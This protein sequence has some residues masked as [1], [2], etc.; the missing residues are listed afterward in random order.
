M[1]HTSF[2]GLIAG[3]SAVLIM[4]LLFSCSFGADDSGT[5]KLSLTDA[6]IADAQSVEGVFIT[7]TSIEYNLNGAWIVDPG[8][9]GPR[10]FN[11]LDL[12]GGTVALLSTTEFSSGQVNQIRFLLDAQQDGETPDA[13]PGSY[14]VI[15]SRGTADGVIDEHDDVH[16]LFVPSGDQS[17]FI[18]VGSFTIPKNGEVEITAD[19]DVRKSVVKR[20]SLDEY[21]LKPTI[22]LVVNNQASTIAGTFS[23]GSETYQAF[24]VFAY[25]DGSYDD[26]EAPVGTEAD[27]FIPFEHAVSSTAA[28]TT[29]GSYSI[30]F[31]AAGMYDLVIVGVGADGSYTV[32]DSMT[33][34]DVVVAAVST[35][36][37]NVSL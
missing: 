28:S 23:A 34:H 29:E 26:S 9:S 36:T 13:S 15:D 2:R 37:Q 17:G 1:K 10:T 30:P 22:R 6:P 35:S 32:I 12:T 21:I 19:F 3:V 14:I 4:A 18:A 27:T 25:A 16:E 8:F 11:L 7:I 5:V 24:T 20:G 33:Y 31:L